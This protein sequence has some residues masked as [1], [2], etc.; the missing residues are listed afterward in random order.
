MNEVN[1]IVQSLEIS[2]ICQYVEHKTKTV[3]AGSKAVKVMLKCEIQELERAIELNN[4][5]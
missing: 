1:D 3:K 5:K 4:Q 2:D